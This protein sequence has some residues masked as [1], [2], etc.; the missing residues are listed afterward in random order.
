M[1]QREPSPGESRVVR[2]IY[3]GKKH[4][5]MS[6]VA[7]IL[8]SVSEQL[9]AHGIHLSIEKC[10]IPR[11][12]AIHG[13]GESANEML[14]LVDLPEQH[15]SL[16]ADFQKSVLRFTLPFPQIPSPYVSI[17]VLPAI[18]HA[19]HGLVR[20]GFQNITLVLKEGS[21]KSVAE[22]FHRFC[23]EAPHP[24]QA[25][26]V[27]LPMKY[28][29]QAFAA[30]R[31]AAGMKGR[32]GVVALY[33]ISASILMTAFMKAGLDVP[34]QVEVVA[35]NTSMQAVRVF[36][37]PTYYPYPMDALASVLCKAAIQYFDRGE[38]PPLRKMI[39]LEVVTP[40]SS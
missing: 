13:A 9:N 4:Q 32:H 5:D 16:F 38:L 17:D 10:D 3:Y 12:K 28:P 14:V 25:R 30:R 7:E 23:A 19:I 31:L 22:A 18:R 29:E 34:R 33:S 40:L 15:R 11:L 8:L 26:V 1:P 20:R 2:W 6:S 27:K 37:V 39:P 21:K 36:P 24:L 35:V